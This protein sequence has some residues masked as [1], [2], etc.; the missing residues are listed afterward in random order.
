MDADVKQLPVSVHHS[1]TVG[2]KKQT[3]R[4]RKQHEERLNLL[5]EE[6]PDLNNPEWGTDT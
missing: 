2:E 4:E 1:H 5:E 3:H 6:V